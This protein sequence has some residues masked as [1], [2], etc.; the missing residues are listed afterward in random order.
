MKVLFVSSGNTKS[1]ISTLVKNQGESLK[2]NGVELGYFPVIGKGVGGYINNIKSLRSKAKNY[3]I[4]HA[5]YGLIGLL[6][7]L[8]HLKKPIVLSIMGSDINGTYSLTGR[9]ELKSYLLTFLTKLSLIKP[10]TIIVKSR[11]ILDKIHQKQKCKVIANGVDFDMFKPMAKDVCREQLGIDKNKKV[12]LF[13]ASEQ[14]AVKNFDLVKK[15]AEKINDKDFMLLSPYPVDHEKI[16]IYLNACDVFILSSFNEGSPN[17]I[18]EAMACNIPVLATNVGDV[19]EVIE[20][21]DGCYLIDF[22]VQD[23]VQKINMA[24]ESNMRTNGRSDIKH[25]EANAVAQEIIKI[26]NKLIP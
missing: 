11:S 23:V 7:A 5:H 9:R 4:I 2:R 6:C 1:G 19:N 25:L 12:L 24:L 21:T 16:P 18:K 17:V 15:A 14:L 13:L 3:D 20:R 22:E 8:A 10:K 26:Y